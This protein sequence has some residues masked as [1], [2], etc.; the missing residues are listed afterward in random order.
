MTF[1]TGSFQIGGSAN[2]DGRGEFIFFFFFLIIVYCPLG[3][4]P[5]V[6]KTYRYV[7]RLHL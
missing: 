2:V 3:H 5:M 1:F 4:C 6:D 7:L